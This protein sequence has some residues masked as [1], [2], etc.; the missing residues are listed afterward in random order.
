[1][2]KKISAMNSYFV[3]LDK[4][5]VQANYIIKMK[6]DQMNLR[7][8]MLRIDTIRDTA[9]VGSAY[10]IVE[11]MT[12]A[13]VVGLIFIDVKPFYA[14]LFITTLTTFLISY[15]LLLIKDL[16]NPFDYSVRGENGTEVSLKPIHDVH[17]ELSAWSPDSVDPWSRSISNNRSFSSYKI[18]G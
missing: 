12:L 5:G 9:F 17:S 13:I 1:M 18:N 14:S 8:A 6:T 15:M 2:L 11:V 10:A 4:E 7:K 16:D 3:Q